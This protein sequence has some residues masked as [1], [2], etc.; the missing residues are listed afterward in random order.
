MNLRIYLCPHFKYIFFFSL[1]TLLLTQEKVP[2]NWNRF[3]KRCV[4][5]AQSP[6]FE[7]LFGTTD[8]FHACDSCFLPQVTNNDTMNHLTNTID[9][10]VDTITKVNHNLFH[11]VVDMMN[12]RYW[13]YFITYSCTVPICVLST[14]SANN[15][16]NT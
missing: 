9:K 7:A 10:H 4:K 5:L 8:H 14:G 11:H 1:A 13:P 2:R 3:S 15:A 16:H 12:A 6:Y